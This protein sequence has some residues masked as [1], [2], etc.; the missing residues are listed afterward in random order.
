[1]IRRTIL[2]IAI[3]VA[4]PAVQATPPATVDDVEHAPSAPGDD[5]MLITAGFLNGHPDLRF[6]LLGLEKYKAGDR[7]RAFRHFQNAAYYADKP[8]Q[9]MLGEMLWNGVGNSRNRSLAYVWMDLAAER[10]YPGFIALRERY[11]DDL[12]QAERRSAIQL[13]QAIHA[14]YGDAAALPRIATKLRRERRSITGSRTGFV[15]NLRII[16]P[17]A[18]GTTQIDGSHFHDERYWDP[19]Q[20][21]AWQDAI[22]MHPRIGTVRVG[23]TEQLQPQTPGQPDR[24]AQ[25]TGNRQRRPL[26]GRVH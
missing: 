4:P 2:A 8:S 17:S 16:V 19:A 18:S 21:R 11:W 3:A 26:T 14:R 25:P 23:S 10:G 20:Y 5:P 13:G 1:M 15:G 12:S 9:A 7:E 6:R 24:Q 22:W